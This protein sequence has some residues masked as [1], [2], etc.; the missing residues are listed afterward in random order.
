M[1]RPSHQKEDQMRNSQIPTES[2]ELTPD[3]LE[4][5]TGGS[6]LHFL[7]PAAV[8]ITGAVLI[9]RE[10]TTGTLQGPLHR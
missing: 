9:T 4:S 5:A 8:I 2:R 10:L 6:F 1:V 7:T 3:E